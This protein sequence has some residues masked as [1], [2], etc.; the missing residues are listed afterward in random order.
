MRFSK[1]LYGIKCTVSTEIPLELKTHMASM[2]TLLILYENP[3]LNSK[4]LYYTGEPR[5]KTKLKINIIAIFPAVVA[6]FQNVSNVYSLIFFHRTAA[7]Q[8]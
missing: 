6:H 2:K 8:S 1:E 7:F 3:S 5:A 4:Y